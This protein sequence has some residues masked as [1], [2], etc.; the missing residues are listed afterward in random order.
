MRL[1]LNSLVFLCVVF[2]VA[3]A[4]GDSLI[5]LNKSGANVSLIDVDS[6]AVRL[7]LKTDPGPHEVAVSPDG[8]RA[9][10]AN[11]GF[12]G[13]DGWQD[14]HT[15]TV[16]DLTNGVVTDTLDLG[17]HFRPHGV[18]FLAD[19]ERVVVTAE[20]EQALIV[21]NVNTGEVVQRVQTDEAASH[22]V[23]V[24][25]ERALAFVANIGG[26]SLSI[27]DLDKG[28]LL[29]T[30]RTG[31]GCEGV[32]ITPNGQQV[33]TTNRAANTLSVIDVQRLD[34]VGE[35]S[36]GKFPIRIKFT[37]DGQRAVVSCAVSS[38]VV[39]F[40]VR[41]R[42]ELARIP[43]AL[44]IVDDAGMRLFGDTMAESPAPVGVLID[45][46]G[47]RAYIA[48]TNADRVVVIDLETYEVVDTLIAGSEPDGLGWAVAAKDD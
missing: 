2:P 12:D 25:A 32:D 18:Q 21:V 14:G 19:G 36:C 26:G 43:L 45:P 9:V 20:A 39:V 10:V 6:G 11:Y 48:A 46:S 40:D 41:T 15:L 13:G 34:I 47:S 44:D 33:W 23:S 31:D 35:I 8:T 1:A 4:A 27:I 24:A 38:E 7:T 28:E 16:I 5:V 3:H 37:P 29:K 17:Q 42:K 22:M 30:L